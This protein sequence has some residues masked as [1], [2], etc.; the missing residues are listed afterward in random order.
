MLATAAEHLTTASFGAHRCQ[1]RRR[2]LASAL[3]HGCM[4]HVARCCLVTCAQSRGGGSRPSFAA[5][6]QS[7]PL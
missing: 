3:V 1:G 4:T 7:M 2:K 6:G 5:A